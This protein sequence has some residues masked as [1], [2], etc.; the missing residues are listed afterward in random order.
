MM[1]FVSLPIFAV[2]V[3]KLVSFISSLCVLHLS[4]LYRLCLY[5]SVLG[6]VILMLV[7]FIH[8]ITKSVPSGRVHILIF[9]LVY[10]F[11]HHIASLGSYSDKS[12]QILAHIH[13]IPVVLCSFCQINKSCPSR[14]T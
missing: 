8:N 1:H 2:S 3:Q 5:G 14:L 13:Q 10:H 12:I 9:L 6:N 7:L 11:L 4:F